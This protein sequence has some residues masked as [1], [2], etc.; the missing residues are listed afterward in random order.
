MVWEF[1]TGFNQ[2]VL[3]PC[4][5]RY[6]SSNDMHEVE[7][8]WPSVKIPQNLFPRYNCTC[9]WKQIAF[10]LFQLQNL[11]VY[12]L[13]FKH[14]TNICL[15]TIGHVFT[16]FRW[17][18]CMHWSLLNIW[19]KHWV[20]NDDIVFINVIIHSFIPTFALF[21]WMYFFIC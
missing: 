17:N 14:L 18:Y 21:S 5:K 4:C 1:K 8:N 20:I 15:L 9:V 7:S 3:L 2:S 16:K 11:Y 19:I 10:Y 12:F 6:F 13:C